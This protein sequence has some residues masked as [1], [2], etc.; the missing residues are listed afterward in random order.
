LLAAFVAE[1]VMDSLSEAVAQHMMDAENK[2]DISPFKD[3]E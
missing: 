3:E 2:K 1:T